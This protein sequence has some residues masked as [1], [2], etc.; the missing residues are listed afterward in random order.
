MS[1]DAHIL[2]LA[3]LA[4]LA[5]CAVGWLHFRSLRGLAH[6]MLAGQPSAVALQL[7]RMAGLG[8]FLYLCAWGGGAAVLLAG[9][10]GV[11]VGRALVLRAAGKEA[12]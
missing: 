11:L 1:L 6:R 9:A 4:A 5:G 8:L 7:A 10:C 2:A 3:G 12:P